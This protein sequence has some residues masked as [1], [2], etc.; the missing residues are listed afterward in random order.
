MISSPT[1]P[2]IEEAPVPLSAHAALY[3]VLMLLIVAIFWSII[4]T[5][6]R[7][8]VA[9]GKIATRTPMLVMQPFTTSRI[10]EFDV[11]ARRPCEKGPGAGAFDPAFA[12]ADVASLEQKVA[13]LTAETRAAGSRACPARTYHRR[14]GRQRRSASPRRQIYQPRK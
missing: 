7:I 5:V 6:D 14:A 12:Q 11:Q 10:I 2:R 8:V 13:S 3:V 9:P 1:P 4:G